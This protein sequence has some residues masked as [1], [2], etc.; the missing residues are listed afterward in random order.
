M[1]EQAESAEIV[2]IALAAALSD[3]KDV[4]GVPETAARGDGFHAVEPESCDARR[5]AR[6]FEG[7]VD[8]DS[9]GAAE[10]ADASVA[11][12]DVVAE[13]AGISAQSPLVDAIVAAEG[14]AALRQYLELAPAAERQ[15]VGAFGERFAAGAATLECSWR[16]H[17]L[18]ILPLGDRER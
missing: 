15:A 7:G 8:R 17:G 9:V 3:G 11:G 6:A 10:G 2:E 16:E 18:S 4:V 5:A 14:A 1:A 13:I 12:E